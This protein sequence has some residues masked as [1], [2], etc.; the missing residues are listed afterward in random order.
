MDSL[1]YNKLSYSFGIINKISHS[2]CNNLIIDYTFPAND[3][4]IATIDAMVECGIPKN[5]A[6]AL[7]VIGTIQGYDEYLLY[8]RGLMVGT[9][10]GSQIHPSV[11]LCHE[12]TILAELLKRGEN[13]EEYIRMVQEASAAKA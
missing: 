2:I 11:L 9:H 12:A 8:K 13:I 10:G 6:K 4:F 5:Y 7:A 1:H 3:Y